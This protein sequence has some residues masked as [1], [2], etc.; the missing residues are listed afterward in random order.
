VNEIYPQLTEQFPQEMERT[1]NKGGTNLTYI[2]VSEVI[3]RMNKVLGV[4]NWSFSIKGYTE[5]GDSIVAHVTVAAMIDGKE[6]SRDGVGGQKIKR[7]KATGLAVDYGDEVKG[8][9]SDALKKAVQTLGVGLYL[10]RSDDA[11]EIEQIMDAPVA[12]QEANAAFNN[13]VSISK[14]FSDEQKSQLNS[15]WI[16]IAGTL[17]K[18]RKATDAPV[19]MLTAL[20]SEAVRLS[21]NGATTTK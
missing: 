13:I 10:A 17:P 8:A 15:K 2:P 4:E 3:N 21:F 16:E 19:E 6:V 5:I 18:P 11:M 12:S 7:I 14:T 1:L 20:H 9:V